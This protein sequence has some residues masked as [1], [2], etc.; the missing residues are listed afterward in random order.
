[1]DSYPFAL[2]L[3]AMGFGIAVAAPVGPMSL[4][5]MRRSLV[6]GVAYGLA[7]GAGI[8]IGDG[9]YALVAALGLA[10][11][12]SFMLAHE[13]PVHL[14]A[15][16]ALLYLGARAFFIKEAAGS[17]E[18]PARAS[19][20]SALSS[21]TLLTLT[22]PPTIIMFAAIFTALAPHTGFSAETALLTVAGVCTGSLLWW[23]GLVA[24]ISV[25]RRMIG[26]ALRRWIDRT[27]GV[28]LGAVGLAEVRAATS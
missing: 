17:S 28:V 18:A 8:A 9:A 20:P 10:G 2:Y 6:Q 15:G 11:V 27:A 25:F 22:N 7:T 19:W 13:R 23:C 26:P 3:K 5:C 21:A 16:V 14:A 1:V 24:V 12:S 4:L